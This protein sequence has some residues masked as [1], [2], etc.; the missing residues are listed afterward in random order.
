MSATSTRIGSVSVA[1]R[2]RGA[3]HG[4]HDLPDLGEL[5]EDCAV[6]RRADHGI[7]QHHVRCLHIRFGR[8]DGCR[9]GSHRSF[10]SSKAIRREIELGL[11]NIL[12]GQEGVGPVVVLP[13][14]PQ[15]RLDVHQCCR[16]HIQS[17]AR[18]VSH[19]L[20]V[21]LLDLCDDVTGFYRTPDGD[22]EVFQTARSLGCDR[23]LTLRHDVAAGGERRTRKIS[24]DSA[25]GCYV[26]L[27]Q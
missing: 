26:H 3:P 25:D 20:N 12:V 7:P 21:V 8:L 11:R 17:R 27:Q 15:L 18:L 16:R 5:F 4:S 13:G 14:I 6:E 2:M 1:A 19:G 22:T 24:S 23:G 9:G 10:G